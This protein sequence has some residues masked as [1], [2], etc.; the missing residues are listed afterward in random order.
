MGKTKEW[1]IFAC[2]FEVLDSKESRQI[3]GLPEHAKILLFG[4]ARID[5]PIKGFHL[6]LNAIQHLI[7]Q[8]IYRKDEL[9]LVTF[10]TYK[11]PKES[12]PQD[13]RITA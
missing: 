11:Y 12:I 5:D 2:W 10:G 3:L 4:A 13:G 8:G 6:L 1:T 9:Y 7:T